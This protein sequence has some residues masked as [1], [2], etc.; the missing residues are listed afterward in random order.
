MKDP[1]VREQLRSAKTPEDVQALIRTYR[2][3]HTPFAD[4]RG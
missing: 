2:R 4:A 1:S 3:L